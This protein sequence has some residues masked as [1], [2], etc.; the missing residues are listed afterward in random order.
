M[1]NSEFKNIVAA[2]D[3]SDYSKI[4][5]K[6]A[7]LLA[8]K[9]NAN[10]IYAHVFEDTSMF[11]TTYQLRKAEYL[12]EM[13]QQVR[14]F[15]KLSSKQTISIRVGNPYE[16]I[17]ELTKQFEK[18]LIIA[19]HRGRNPISRLFIGSTAEKLAL[20]STYP[21]WIH[22]GNKSVLPK[23]IMAPF[24]FSDRTDRAV[25]K[26]TELNKT[27]G[28][29]LE[30]YHVMQQ[31][32]PALDFQAYSLMFQEVKKIDDEGMASFKK[33]YP[34]LKTKRAT[35]WVANCIQDHSERFDLITLVPRRD[36]SPGYFGSVTT[37]LIRT[38]DKP[39]LVLP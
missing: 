10:I 32:Y 26:L 2:I 15:Y 8:K 25:A 21:L 7:K 39:I 31:P 22:R 38:G 37:K 34:L 1:K 9:L 28:S 11:N 12:R 6:E 30:M 17:I 29:K 33:K 27:F 23:R 35:G 4:V 24:D 18:P 19:G 13:V 5:V 36:N 20:Q 16:Q 3:F 14:K